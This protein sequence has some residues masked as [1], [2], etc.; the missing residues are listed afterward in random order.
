MSNLTTLKF[1][2]RD[3]WW[4]NN[5]MRAIIFVAPTQFRSNHE[6]NLV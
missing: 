2:R 4:D 1:L 5:K 3:D 6:L